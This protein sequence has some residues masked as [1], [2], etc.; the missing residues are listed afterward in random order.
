M[1]TKKN[2]S[3][4]EFLQGAA[5]T[6]VG[7]LAAA[8]APATPAPAEAPAEA[9]TEA[10]APPAKDKIVVGLSRPL[11]GWNAVIGD[12]AF[13][14]VYETFVEEVNADGGVYVEEYGKKLPI[15]LIVYDDKSDVGTMTRLTE[16]LIVEDKVDFLW[17]A[18]GTAFL[19]AQAP[20]ANKYGYVLITAEGG[21]TSLKDMLPSLPYV[22]VT[23]SFSDW[24]QI[25][26]LADILSEAGAKTA[27]VTYIADLHGIEYSGVSGIEFPKKGI[28]VVGIK[29]LPPDIKDLSPVIKDAKASE[30]DIFCCFAYPDQN[31]P[32]TGTSMELGYNPKAWVGGPGINFGFYHTAFGPAVEGVMG[33]TSFNPKQSEAAKALADK[34]WAGKPED[35]QDPWGHPLYWAGLET[36]KQAIEKVGTLDQEKIRE[37]LATEKFDT[38]LGETWY[39]NGLLSKDC[40]TGEIGQWINGLFEVVGPKEHAT[41][42]LV[43]PK[44]EWPTG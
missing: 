8:C 17:P 11:S 3:R 36:W 34:L 23:L 22:F 4:R 43:Y 16:K 2:L 30:A 28:E 20:I 40:H 37:I 29:S 9:P 42:E 31:M 18:S 39:E 10:P 27:Y 32:A 44:P 6:G 21:A 38:V 25:P 5:L 26:V 13:R 7:L 14:P 19:F 33:F 41:A 1:N 15:E 12:S 24:Y 35:V